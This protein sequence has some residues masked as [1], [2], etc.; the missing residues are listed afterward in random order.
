MIQSWG[1]LG[2]ILAEIENRISTLEN[3]LH[4]H[5][6]N[7]PEPFYPPAPPEHQLFNR[8]Q[9]L[10]GKLLHFD[11]KFNEYTDRAKRKKDKF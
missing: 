11:K 10:E 4:G 6:E 9:Q 2:E 1:E 5:E 3:S 8:L 7:K